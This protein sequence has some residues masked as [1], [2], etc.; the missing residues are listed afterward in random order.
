M[1]ELSLRLEMTHQLDLEQWPARSPDEIC[2]Y[3]NNKKDG[4]LENCL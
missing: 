2:K 3:K 4:T 1:A